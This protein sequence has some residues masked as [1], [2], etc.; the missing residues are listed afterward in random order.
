M[1]A[2]FNLAASVAGGIEIELIRGD[3]RLIQPR[4]EPLGENP[5]RG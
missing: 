1:G 3:E 2:L 4:P 5:F